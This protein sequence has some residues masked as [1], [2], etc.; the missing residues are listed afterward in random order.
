[1]TDLLAK[2]LKF[3]IIGLLNAVLDTLI[4]KACSNQISKSPKLLKLLGNYNLNQYSGAQIISFVLA[5]I[6]SFYLNSTFTWRINPF[7]S[8]TRGILYIL[9]SLTAWAATVLF[10]N[11]MTNDKH[12]ER[13]NK[14]FHNLEDKYKL[15]KIIK[16]KL[17]YPLF[18]KLCSII[19][20]MF[21]NFIGYNFLVFR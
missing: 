7:D 1:M 9:V 14:I 17:E 11:I 18:I 8:A 5:L 15:P 20:S 4:W 12:L 6:S 19:I 10:I 16:E 13:F 3:A 21:I 2:F